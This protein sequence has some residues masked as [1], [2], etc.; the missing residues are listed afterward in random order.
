MNDLLEVERSE[1]FPEAINPR[2]QVSL[3]A[4]RGRYLRG[5]S[6]ARPKGACGRL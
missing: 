2:L 4:S 6:K 3:I 1:T 5:R